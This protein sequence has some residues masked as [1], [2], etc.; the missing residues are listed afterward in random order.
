MCRHKCNLKKPRLLIA[1]QKLGAI[2]Q[3]F[4]GRNSRFCEPFL[5]A[6]QSK[7]EMKSDWLILVIGPL[8]INS[9]RTACSK[10]GFATYGFKQ[11]IN[12]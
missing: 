5:V 9:S 7:M 10:M 1:Q 3:L 12:I 4:Y 8:A 11:M 2:R 6:S